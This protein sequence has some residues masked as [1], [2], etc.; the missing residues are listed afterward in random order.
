MKEPKKKPRKARG[1][2]GKAL[3]ILFK[4]IAWLLIITLIRQSL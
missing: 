3:R 4:I 2:Y 1:R